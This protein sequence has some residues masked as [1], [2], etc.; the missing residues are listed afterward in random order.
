M[1]DNCKSSNLTVLALSVACAILLILFILA[2]TDKGGLDRMKTGDAK[3]ISEMT[4]S[5]S[6]FGT[7]ADGPTVNLPQRPLNEP[8]AQQNQMGQD[9]SSLKLSTDNID[10]TD[11]L[12]DYDPARMSLEKSVFD[13]HREFVEDAYISTQGANST[14]SVRDDAQDINPRIGL[15]KIDYT[16]AFS[17]SS[18]R[19]VSSETPDQIAQ[20]TN[21]FVI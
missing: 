2:L 7:R 12:Q 15:R 10:T 9:L 17:E 18:A 14:D 13:S 3:L 6:Q 4:P 8:T 21:S 16:N 1:S 11:P 5:R 19:V 20:T